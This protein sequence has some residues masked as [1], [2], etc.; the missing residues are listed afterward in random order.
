MRAKFNCNINGKITR[1]FLRFNM[2]DLGIM[3]EI[4][5]ELHKLLVVNNVYS[6]IF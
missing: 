6:N 2:I 3:D 4:G 5:D 1:L